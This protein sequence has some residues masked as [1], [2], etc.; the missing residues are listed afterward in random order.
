MMLHKGVLCKA[1]EKNTPGVIYHLDWDDLSCISRSCDFCAIFS[2]QSFL[3]G[4]EGGVVGGC[5]MWGCPCCA[6]G[7]AKAEWLPEAGL[8]FLDAAI[9]AL[10]ASVSLAA[11]ST[12]GMFPILCGIG[13]GMGLLWVLLVSFSLAREGIFSG[14][15][16]L[17]SQ[18]TAK[19]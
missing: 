14:V 6:G 13:V 7:G 2:S 10:S 9:L 16:P 18:K 3:C 11:L 5:G 12:G 1:Q 8:F 15:K 4:S 19:L 17:N